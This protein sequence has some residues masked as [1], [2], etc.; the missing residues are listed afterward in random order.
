M[1]TLDGVYATSY[2]FSQYP[3][4]EFKD[5]A[6]DALNPIH[7]NAVGKSDTAPSLRAVH[8][9]VYNRVTALWETKASDSASAA[10][11]TFTLAY[12]IPG[13]STQY[14]DAGNWVSS[15]VYQDK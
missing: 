10:G 11:A 15:R 8:L 3:L 1:A 7:L 14:L 9:Q 4:F 13:G 5:K 2:A 6:P 12:I